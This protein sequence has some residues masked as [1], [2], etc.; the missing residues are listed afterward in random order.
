MKI[1]LEYIGNLNKFVDDDGREILEHGSNDFRMSVHKTRVLPGISISLYYHWHSEL[2]ILYLTKGKMRA[3]IGDKEYMLKN[4]DIFIIPSNVPHVAY[5]VDSGDIE[6]YAVLVHMLFLSSYDYDLIQEK[7]IFPIFMGWENIR[8]K[9]TSTC[10]YYNEI[11][12]KLESIIDYYRMEYEGYELMIKSCLYSI[13]YYLVAD[14]QEVGD[15]GYNK[16]SNKWVRDILA[17][18]K[19]NYNKKISLTEMAEYVQMSPGYLCRAMKRMFGKSPMKF[20]N[21]YRVLQAVR[22]MENT[23]K[24]LIDIAYETGFSNVNNFTNSFKNV[25]GNTPSQF[26]KKILKKE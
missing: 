8:K 4:G 24:K 13:F 6:Y 1:T 5:R 16:Y 23:N 9:I 26:Y 3:V 17:F 19:D 18:I 14:S 22:L 12:Q 21:H 20:V 15:Y 25:M 10:K 11:L 7:Y 2:E